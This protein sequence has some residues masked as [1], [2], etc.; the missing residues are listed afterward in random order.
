MAQVSRQFQIFAK[1]AGAACNFSCSYCYYLKKGKLYEGKGPPRMSDDLLERYIIQHIEASP[2]AT[3][4][5]SW[6]GG[7]PTILGLDCFRKIVALEKENC[8]AGKTIENGIQTNGF[9]LD[10]EWCRFFFRERFRVGLSLDGPAPMH[11]CYRTTKA[12]EATHVRVMQSF[13]L[14]RRYQVP[15]DLL[16]VVHNR[17]VQNPLEVYRFL[18][19]IGGRFIGFLP[20]VEPRMDAPLGVSP[21]SVSAED[22]GNFLCTIFDEWKRRDVGSVMVQ[23]FEEAARA[24][25]GLEHS[26]CIF[27]KICGD[28]PVIEHNGDFYSCDH[29]VDRDHL[30]GNVCAATLGELLESP[31]QLAFGMAKRATLPRYCLECPVL[32]TCNGGCPKDRFVKTPDGEPG[33]NY[34]CAGL[35]R[36]FIYSRPHLAQLAFQGSNNSAPDQIR[37][38]IQEF[39]KRTFPSA[40]RNDPCP[41]G[42]GRKYKKCCLK[43]VTG[44]L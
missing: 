41:C 28:I 9:L 30:L 32:A 1:P 19:G 13:E 11:D 35:R 43:T 17:N 18:K 7:E 36:F 27:R 24:A 5:F 14:L 22:Y 38:T 40:G 26:L 25:Q 3:I 15:C 29:F 37:E 6:H 12:R 23:I 33:L 34:L 2:D 16:C 31:A 44:G 10:E 21:Q 39:G 42:S 8:P 20:V 4:T